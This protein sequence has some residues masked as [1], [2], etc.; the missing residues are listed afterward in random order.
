MRNDGLKNIINKASLKARIWIIFILIFLS[1]SDGILIIVTIF[2]VKD[3]YVVVTLIVSCF[4]SIAGI[5]IVPYCILSISEAIYDGNNE[6]KS[7]RQL[8]REKKE[9]VSDEE[10]AADTSNEM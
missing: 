10:N 9:K 3:V 2:V 4:S 5:V 6:W 8:D 1:L 7:Q